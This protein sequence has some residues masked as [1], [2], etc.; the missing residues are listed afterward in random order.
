MRPTL[1][2]WR[3][4]TAYLPFP[5]P[6]LSSSQDAVLLSL[7]WAHSA[8]LLAG[9][10]ARR[11]RPSKDAGPTLL[12]PR[13]HTRDDRATRTHLRASRLIPGSGEGS[14]L[15]SVG[16]G[17]ALAAAVVAAVEQPALSSRVVAGSSVSWFG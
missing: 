13:K 14:L 1:L 11:A 16:R 7:R 15:A 4:S 17:C 2:R 5:F 12:A 6:I 3:L 9:N 8:V 10:D